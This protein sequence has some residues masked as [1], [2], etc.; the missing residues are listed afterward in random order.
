MPHVYFIFI[1]RKKKALSNSLMRLSSCLVLFT[2]LESLTSIKKIE[3]KK[4]LGFC[5]WTWP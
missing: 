4:N 5:Y 1:E 2:L 3:G